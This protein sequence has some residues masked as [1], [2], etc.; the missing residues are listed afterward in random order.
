MYIDKVTQQKVVAWI[1]S[2]R[3]EL[4][5]TFP[6]LED[7]IVCCTD[8]WAVRHCIVHEATGLVIPM[9]CDKYT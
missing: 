5:A 2:S 3:E 6:A 9:V 4:N 7:Q 1:V 8:S